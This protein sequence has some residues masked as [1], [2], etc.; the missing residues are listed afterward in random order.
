MTHAKKFRWVFPAILL[1]T[2]AL[3]FILYFIWSA[4]AGKRADYARLSSEQYNAVFLS[5]YPI[6]TYREDDYSYYRGMDIVKTSY[7][8][9]DFRT[10]SAYMERIDESG[11][12]VTNI[13]LGIRPERISAEELL[14]LIRQH[15]SIYF[16]VVL[17]YPSLDYW[18][19]LSDRQLS[20][21]LQAL[22]DCIAALVPE[23]NT[24]VCYFGASQWLIS[25]PANY[26]DDFLVNEHIAST[27]MLHSDADHGYALNEKN[28]ENATLMLSELITLQRTDPVDYPDL[29]D[30]EMVFFGDSVVANYEGSDSIPGVVN[31]LSGASVYKCGQGGTSACWS[32]LPDVSLLSTVDAFVNSDFA[33]LPE[34]TQAREGLKQYLEA[35]SHPDK[36][37]FIINYG[38]NDYFGGVPVFA[39]DPFD[40]TTYSGA[41]R[42]AVD[43]L[44]EAYPSC[45]IILCTPNF[46][47]YFGNGTQI[48][49]EEGGALEDYAEAARAVAEESG[50]R[51]LDNYTALGITEKDYSHY[52]IDGCHPN[53]GFRYL[54]G[55]RIVLLFS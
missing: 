8:I 24:N 11:N 20:R 17:S 12:E 45:E 29:S 1:A 50:V 52:L 49:S 6:D 4:S 40:I 5:M 15:P 43:A 35:S 19:G 7:C 32:P 54:I 10:L 53:A 25:N 30:Y 34:G 51:L 31:G 37:C 22:K 13:Y 28:A 42:T 18:A 36:L 23:S 9:P 16:E 2:L 26:L 41:L 55:S 46:T 21:Q 14:S 48:Q 44:Q 38:L 47:T 39:E 33:A 3:I 27:L